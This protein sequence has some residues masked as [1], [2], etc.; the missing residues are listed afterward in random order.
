MSV[1]DEIASGVEAQSHVSWFDVRS[2]ARLP[3]KNVT[4]RI[5]GFRL[6]A[7]FHARETVAGMFLLSARKVL[8]IEKDIRVVNDAFF[9]R[10]DLD[11][12]HPADIAKIGG[13]N[14]V[15][16]V[17]D[18]RRDEG[19]RLPRMKDE[20]GLAELPSGREFRLGRKVARISLRDAL[21]RPSA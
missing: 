3:E 19:V 1:E 7:Q 9:T 11:C 6:D 12:L 18:T 17:V 2:R 16:I 13:K 4:V 5:E 21:R 14:E 15:P 10:A 8:A 20:V